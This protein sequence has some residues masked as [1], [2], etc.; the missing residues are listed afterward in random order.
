[1][2]EYVL[3]IYKQPLS[4]NCCSTIG[5]T[6]YLQSYVK[7]EHFSINLHNLLI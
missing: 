6:L 1:M 5:Y 7:D 4:E 3:Y 2:H